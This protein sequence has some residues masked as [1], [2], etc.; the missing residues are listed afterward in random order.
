MVMK[1]DGNRGIVIAVPDQLTVETRLAVREAA[2]RALEEMEGDL[3]FDLSE[4]E[5]V[6]STGLGL[7]MSVQQAAEKRRR[8]VRIVG[9]SQELRHLFTLTRLEDDFGFYPSLDAA[10]S[11]NAA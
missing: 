1:V 11:E 2:T 4:T 9:L 3:V 6:D 8:G 7:L 10:L 5:A